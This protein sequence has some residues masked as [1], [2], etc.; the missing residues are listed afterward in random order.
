M[1]LLLRVQ[2]KANTIIDY[3]FFKFQKKKL[4]SEIKNNVNK[5]IYLFA[6]PT[7][8][9]LGDQAQLYCWYQYFAEQY[10]AYRIIDVPC[11]IADKTLLSLIKSKIRLDDKLFVHS[12]Y[13]IYDPH[14]ELSFIS[15][16]VDFFPEK[17]ITILPQTIN[18]EKERIIKRVA[19]SFN[20]HPFL[21]LIC[22]D[23][24]S[25]KKAQILFHKC[26]LSLMPDVVTSLIGTKTFSTW[27]NRKEDVLFCLRNDGE[28]FYSASELEDLRQSLGELKTRVLD[29]TINVSKRSWLKNRAHYIYNK[30]EEFSKYKVIVTDRYHGTIFSLIANTPVI[31]IASADHK[32]SSGVDWFPKEEFGKSIFFANNLKEVRNLVFSIIASPIHIQNP[33]Y[34]KTNYYS[35]QIQMI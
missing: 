32:L 22:R 8:S 9:N 16:V 23:K 26:N 35:K 25:Y 15:N 24:V 27:R 18:L 28:K 14:P 21:N 4:I 2:R 34:F 6:S 7:H 3:Y 29:T 1:N 12:G 11:R 20:N 31:V 13:L 17:E 33:D 30:I 5:T 10:P 19:T